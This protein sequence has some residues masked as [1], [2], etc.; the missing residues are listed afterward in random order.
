[1][2]ILADPEIRQFRTLV[3]SLLRFLQTGP[4]YAT[5]Y[6]ESI[7]AENSRS[8]SFLLDTDYELQPDWI[9]RSCKYIRNMYQN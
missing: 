9:F 3:N 1:M 7:L 6:T 5:R 4:L 8:G 2:Q